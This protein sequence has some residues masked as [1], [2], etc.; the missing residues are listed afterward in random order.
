MDDTAR[1]NGPG[2]KEVVPDD[3]T[4]SVTESDEERPRDFDP[5]PDFPDDFDD[6][7]P[8]RESVET[9]PGSESG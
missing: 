1:S 2:E 3:E 9:V 8:L 4:D 6:D 7:N 5:H